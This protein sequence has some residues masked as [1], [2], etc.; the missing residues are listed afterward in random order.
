MLY[1]KI[2]Q[3][4]PVKMNAFILLRYSV[5]V[6]PITLLGAIDASDFKPYQWEWEA[7]TK[8]FDNTPA[9]QCPAVV[10]RRCV[11]KNDV[12]RSTYL[13][14]CDFL[15]PSDFHQ[16]PH[17]TTHFKS[18]QKATWVI[19]DGSFD[20]V[21]GLLYLDLSWNQLITI[22]S[23]AFV[24]LTNLVVLDLS[25]NMFLTLGEFLRPLSSLRVLNL[26]GVKVTSV[27]Q[28]HYNTVENIANG[29]SNLTQLKTLRFSCGYIS[30]ED[31]LLL[32]DTS[33]TYLSIISI[34]RI[35]QGAFSPWNAL[36]S[37][38]LNELFVTSDIF[39]NLS[40]FNVERLYIEGLLSG[41]VN[42]NDFDSPNL[43]ALRSTIVM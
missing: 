43:R 1:F 31:V 35:E 11:C 19:P 14:D 18:N 37:L 16:L 27:T 13:V 33:V 42:L 26:D 6:L 20:K 17:N 12:K 21:T 40:G 34:K 22:E 8:D 10:L 5:L 3:Q 24:G 39:K 7:N 38:E 25:G 36:N 9:V 28:V 41:E 4:N 32:Q 15:Q 2:V 30:K 29:I 23:D